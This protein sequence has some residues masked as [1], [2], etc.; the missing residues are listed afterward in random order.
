MWNAQSHQIWQNHGGSHLIWHLTP[1]LAIVALT[2]RQA[3]YI[4]DQV[5]KQNI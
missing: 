3:D 5:A 1:T 4:A 2:I